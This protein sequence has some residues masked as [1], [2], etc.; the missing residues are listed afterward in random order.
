MDYL[1]QIDTGYACGG[2]VCNATGIVTDAPPIFRWMI[3]KHFRQIEK[4]KKI[5][6]IKRAK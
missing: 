5:K 6:T 1:F 4:W 2:I 3:G